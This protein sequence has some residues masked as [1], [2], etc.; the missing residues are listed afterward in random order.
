MSQLSVNA[1]LEI[2]SN[3]KF[4]TLVTLY[5]ELANVIFTTWLY[6]HTHTHTHT[7]T[8]TLTHAGW[9]GRTQ[10][11][12]QTVRLDDETLI[13]PELKK[14][15]YSYK[16]LFFLLQIATALLQILLTRTECLPHIL[17]TLLAQ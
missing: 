10:A 16:C 17:F 12:I 7:C 13:T 6:P 1:R 2:G 8:H 9:C 14:N 4:W 11:T 5:T 15:T 3:R